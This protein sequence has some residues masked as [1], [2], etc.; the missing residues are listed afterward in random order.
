[1]L[2][3]PECESGQRNQWWVTLMLVA[4]SVLIPVAIAIAWLNFLILDEQRFVRTVSPVIETP[5][6]QATVTETLVHAVRVSIQTAS[7]SDPRLVTIVNESGGIDVLMAGISPLIGHAVRSNEFR[8]VWTDANRLAH[9]NVIRLL[10]NRPGDTSGFENELTLV[11]TTMVQILGVEPDS[12]AGQVLARI[13]PELAPRISVL[14]SVEVPAART[15]IDYA[16]WISLAAIIL[17]A[18]LLGIGLWRARNRRQGLILTGV[19][20]LFVSFPIALLV[21]SFLRNY[22]GDTPGVQGEIAREYAR[23]LTA[24]LESGFLMAAA[25]GLIVAFVAWFWPRFSRP[26]VGVPID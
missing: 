7:A 12:Q 16:L 1:M 9:T 6:V 26:S 24:S 18:S 3:K 21:R 15:A 13:P 4:A 2:N 5:A 25:V 14:Q 11:F 20:G 22:L 8:I 10:V 23:A 17:A 19:L